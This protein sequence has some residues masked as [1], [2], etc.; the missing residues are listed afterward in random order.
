MG[1]DPLAL[2]SFYYLGLTPEGSYQFVNANQ[3]ARQLNWTIDELMKKLA[4][5][6]IDPDA[7]L[8]AAFPLAQH[9]VNFQLAADREDSEQLR[10]RASRI[11]DAYLHTKERGKKR[12]WLREIEEEREADRERRRGN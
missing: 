3:V 4:K 7:V 2:F 9:Q 12:N 11:F 6:K 5:H 10:D 1:D 8:N